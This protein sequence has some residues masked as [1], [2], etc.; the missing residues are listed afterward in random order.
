[1][2]VAIT[3]ISGFIGTH[4]K[5]YLSTMAGVEITGIGKS[6]FENIEKLKMIVADHDVIVHLAAINRHDNP[7][8]L[9]RTNI[10]LVELLIQSIVES[11]SNPYL[12]FSSSLQ[13]D[14]SNPYG[15]SK[16]KGQELLEE[17][18][19]KHHGRYAGLVIPNVFGPFGKP[20]YN[21][22]IATFC[23]QITRG[24]TPVIHEDKE[25]QLIYVNDLVSMIW[26][27]INDPQ[28]GRI[29]I[30]HQFQIK[31]SELL[32]TLEMF[33]QHYLQRREIPP[34]NTPFELA[35]FNTFRCYIPEE[36]YPMAFVK[37]EDNRGI[38]V[39]IMRNQSGGQFSFSTTKPGITRGNHFH[40]RKVERFAVIKGKAKIKL[41]RIDK[42]EVIEYSLSGERPSFVD[43]PVWHTHN[44]T[45]IGNQE[46]ITLF[47]IN[48]PYDPSNADTF[49]LDV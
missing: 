17:W 39:E 29:R 33:D 30:N 42:K 47:W 20:F 13:E 6:D 4:L 27:L 36:K 5:N 10:S 49:F 15:S 31:V 28:Y 46:L 18:S 8:D 35:L 1:M 19:K 24:E 12:I 38:F 23:H 44:I 37:N 25:I 7:D 21:S 2:K 3:G 11:K 32:A 14:S 48:E 41:R 40:T 16:R 43:M 22:V 26:S 9:F 45:N 34:L